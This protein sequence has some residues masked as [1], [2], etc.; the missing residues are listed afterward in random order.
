M[1]ENHCLDTHLKVRTGLGGNRTRISDTIT[2]LVPISSADDD[3]VI[4]SIFQ[5]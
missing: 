2:W 1:R 4:P 3:D 5:T